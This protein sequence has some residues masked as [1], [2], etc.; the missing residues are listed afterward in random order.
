[1]GLCASPL[2]ANPAMTAV[3]SVY[4]TPLWQARAVEHRK[5]VVQTNTRPTLDIPAR[6]L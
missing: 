4:I 6:L 5:R 2:D 3:I 1:M